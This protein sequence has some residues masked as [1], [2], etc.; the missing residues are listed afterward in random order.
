MRRI[1]FILLDCWSKSLQVRAGATDLPRVP[2]G[3]SSQGTALLFCVMIS[4]I[5]ANKKAKGPMT[6]RP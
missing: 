3:L 5:G 4:G 1:K 6:S 2:E